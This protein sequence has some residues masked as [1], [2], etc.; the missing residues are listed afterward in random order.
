MTA[1]TKQHTNAQH[2]VSI[3]RGDIIGLGDTPEDARE[4]GSAVSSDNVTLCPCAPDLAFALCDRFDQP[5]TIVNGVATL[6]D[7]EDASHPVTGIDADPN[8]WAEPED[9]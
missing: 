5:F 8:R 9:D 3:Y 4:D 1:S 2:W 7:P 6:D